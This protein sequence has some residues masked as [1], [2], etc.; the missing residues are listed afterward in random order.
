MK[1]TILFIAGLSFNVFLCCYPGKTVSADDLNQV[2]DS[3][4]DTL[5]AGAI[6]K[7]TVTCRPVALY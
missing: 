1:K 5:R 2:S 6:T 7:N 3:R 4:G